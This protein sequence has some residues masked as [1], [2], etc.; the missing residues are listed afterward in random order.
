MDSE[1][2]QKWLDRYVAAWLAYAPD[3]IVG[4]FSEDVAYRYHPYDEPIVGRDAVVASWL[5]ESASGG[6]S[7]RDAPGTYSAEY[8]PVAVDGDTVVATGTSRYSDVPG[9]PVV[10]TYENCFILRFDDE[11]RCREFTEY[12]IRRPSAGSR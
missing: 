1:S 4:L 12:Y 10:K 7:T 5:G 6:A 3:D 8:S 11:G 9:G 2:A